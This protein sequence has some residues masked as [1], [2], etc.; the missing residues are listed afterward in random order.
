MGPGICEADTE[1]KSVIVC[2]LMERQLYM[3]EKPLE[4]NI[5]EAITNDEWNRKN[6]FMSK[7]SLHT[8]QMLLLPEKLAAKWKSEKELIGLLLQYFHVGT[9]G[10]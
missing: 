8:N 3:N 7:R 10:R 2:R 5:M 9:S 4:T 6:T 1:G